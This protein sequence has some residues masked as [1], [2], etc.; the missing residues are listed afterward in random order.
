MNSACFCVRLC[1]CVY[2][3]FYDSNQ[4]CSKRTVHGV[5]WT[6]RL[7]FRIF[8]YYLWVLLCTRMLRPVSGTRAS[9][10]FA[11]GEQIRSSCWSHVSFARSGLNP[12]VFFL[13]RVTHVFLRFFLAALQISNIRAK[14]SRDRLSSIEASIG[15]LQVCLLVLVWWLCVVVVLFLLLLRWWW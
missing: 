8:A 12:H 11:Q 15:S 9:S 3:C 2:P 7:S 13:P 4:F 5:N 1:R 6:R 10:A 14:L